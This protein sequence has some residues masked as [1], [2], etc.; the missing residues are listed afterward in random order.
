MFEKIIIKIV[1]NILEKI[2]SCWLWK[3]GVLIFYKYDHQ[4]FLLEISTFGLNAVEIV[5]FVLFIALVIAIIA[6]FPASESRDS[7]EKLVTY[8]TNRKK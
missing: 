2:N 6:A 1:K 4:K 5:L 7:L 8:T 3:F